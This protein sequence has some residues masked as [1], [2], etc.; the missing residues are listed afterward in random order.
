MY[1]PLHIID[2]ILTVA[3]SLEHKEK[4]RCVHSELWMKFGVETKS[5]ISFGFSASIPLFAY[6]NFIGETDMKHRESYIPGQPSLLSIGSSF[7]KIIYPDYISMYNNAGLG[8]L[9]SSTMR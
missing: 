9:V 6:L 3:T 1:L 8:F 4:L 7:Y 2:H 5:L